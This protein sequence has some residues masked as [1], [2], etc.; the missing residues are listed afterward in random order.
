MNFSTVIFSLIFSLITF[1]AHAQMGLTSV[2]VG[3]TLPTLQTTLTGPAGPDIKYQP[4]P[5]NR[6][7]VGLNFG[8][9]LLFINANSASSS[10]VVKYGETNV[11]GA[12]FLFYGE[13]HTFDLSYER[14]E[15]FNINNSEEVSPGWSSP[16]RIQRPDIV[17]DKFRFKYQYTWSP[18]DFS[19]GIFEQSVVP[20]NSGG[21]FVIGAQASQK[22]LS[23]T[24]PLVP[25]TQTA[26]YGAMGNLREVKMTTVQAGLGGGYVFEWERFYLAWYGML[27]GGPQSQALTFGAAGATTTNETG[28][29]FALGYDARASI[30]Y[31]ADHFFTALNFVR[32]YQKQEVSSGYLVTTDDEASIWL[33][34]RF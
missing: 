13:F 11:S 30:G 9:C 4:A 18:Q 27:W 24:T 33:G 23:G 25:T 7:G 1:Q 6:Y 5:Q 19:L 14:Y 29:V 31:N 10:D 21:S 3:Y 22:G 8:P 26:S 28:S 17:K 15:G 12:S 32:E 16:N 2:K 20:E 34:W